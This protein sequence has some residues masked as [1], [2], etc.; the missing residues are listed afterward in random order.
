MTA[1]EILSNL[2]GS[3]MDDERILSARERELLASLLQHTTTHY[4]LSGQRGNRD[5]RPGSWGSYR[6]TCLRNIRQQHRPASS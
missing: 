2:S 4:G 3:L 1:Q 5:H 6:T